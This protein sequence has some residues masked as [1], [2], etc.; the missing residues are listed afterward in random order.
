MIKNSLRQSGNAHV[1]III[2]LVV[3]VVGL[4][5]FVFWQNFIKNGQSDTALVQDTSQQE[6]VS[7]TKEFKSQDHDI[8]F[9]Y[10]ADWSVVERVETDNTPQWY[11]SYVDVLNAQG[12]VVSSLSTGGQIGGL[13]AEDSALVP[14]S[15]IMKDPLELKG[16]GSTSFGYTIVETST[17]NY[18]IAFGLVENDEPHDNDL[19]LG[20][21]S[22]RCP[23]MS[24]NYRYYIKSNNAAL[25]GMTVGL[26]YAEAQ[27]EGDTKTHQIF[28]SS[29]EAKAYAESDE[30]KHVKKMI[31]SLSI[32][33]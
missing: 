31:K 4:L 23:G 21:D 25:G 33:K 28:K 14:I 11:V 29:D 13:C 7:T 8:T 26:W 30:F 16:V 17:N 20:D 6:T 24:V 15:T 10:P 3:A 12:K 2:I 18:G 9:S 32:G 5:G 19:Q 22:V 1:I 27:R